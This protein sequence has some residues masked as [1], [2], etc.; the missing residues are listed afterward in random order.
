MND[1]TDDFIFYALKNEELCIDGLKH[2]FKGWKD[3][4]DEDGNVCGGTTVCSKCGLDAFTY[5]LRYGS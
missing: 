3:L 1:E 5:S 4:T 2:D